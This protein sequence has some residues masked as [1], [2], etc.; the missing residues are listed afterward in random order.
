MKKREA[1]TTKKTVAIVGPFAP[2]IFQFRG[3][4]IR[5]LL[6]AGLRVV[7]LAPDFTP[8]HMERLRAWGAVPR[9]YP[10][11]RTGLHPGHDLRTLF[12][13]W[14]VFREERP[15]VV[16]GYHPKPSV[17]VPVAGWL[18][19]VPKRVAW[20]GGLGYAFTEG[21]RSW[22]RRGVRWMLTLWYRL[23][24]R[25]AH[26]VWFQNPDDRAELLRRGLVREKLAVVVGGT[27]VDLEAWLPAPSHLKP[28]TFTL[29]AR[30][31]RE[32]GVLEFIEAARCIKPRHPEVKFLL[33]GPV[34]VNPGAIPETQ[35]RSWVN[36]GLVEWVSWADDVRPY[37][38]RTSVFVLPSYR[39]G[40]PRSTQEALAMARPV[41]TTDAPG[42]RETV[43]GGVNGF[44][45]PPK[46]AGALTEAMERFIMTPDLIERMG[47]ASRRLAEDRF[48]VRK[49]NARLIREL[50][51]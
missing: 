46:D 4:L 35:V 15:D 17:Y 8:E 30:L 1:M 3:P 33:V 31:L 27:G 20:V 13:L 23:A 39:E 12:A 2:S 6:R 5:D 45:V 10:L 21:G 40:I 38:R 34:D 29:I 37:L 7:V 32:K 22:K 42:C 36:E 48:D 51:R 49:I 50:L 41:I 16:L 11:D 26:Q 9:L 24:F 43:V 28:L 14:R 47:K 19:R 18:A 44:L 25:V